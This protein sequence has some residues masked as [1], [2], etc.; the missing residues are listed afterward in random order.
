MSHQRRAGLRGNERHAES[1]VQRTRRLIAAAKKR[2][3]ELER[4]RMLNDFQFDLD[5]SKAK[6][7]G[8]PTVRQHPEITRA[9]R[10][11]TVRT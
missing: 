2:K 1:R 3:R 10:K 8:N 11:K 9:N 5:V 6:R 4:Q 7:R